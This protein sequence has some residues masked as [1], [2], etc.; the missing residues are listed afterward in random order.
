MRRT[1]KVIVGLAAAV[2]V[3]AAPSASAG[4]IPD[5]V[6]CVTATCSFQRVVAGQTVKVDCP[7]GCAVT[8]NRLTVSNGHCVS[9]RSGNAYSTKCDS[10]VWGHNVISGERCDESGVHSDYGPDPQRTE[11]CHSETW[12]PG[13]VAYRED[14]QETASYLVTDRHC[15]S[16]TTGALSC[17]GTVDSHDA[18]NSPD[19]HYDDTST[20]TLV[21]GSQSIAVTCDW[22][23]VETGL[24]YPATIR[25]PTFCLPAA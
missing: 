14:C 8:V 16:T 17:T 19:N 1:C 5:V 12:V 3:S 20:C 21:V 2:A 13:A 10:G 22:A 24:N 25:Q 7:S 9:T 11:T 23:P 6:G 4:M 18:P 15:S